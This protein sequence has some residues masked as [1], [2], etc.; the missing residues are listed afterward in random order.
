MTQR[1]QSQW[2][3]VPSGFV[4]ELRRAA[5]DAD[6]LVAAAIKH[7]AETLARERE[8]LEAQWG[9]AGDVSPEDLRVALTRYRP[10]FQRLLSM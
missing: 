3:E 8:N 10:L 1:L 9:R 6:A 7:I 5:Q 4:D 2:T